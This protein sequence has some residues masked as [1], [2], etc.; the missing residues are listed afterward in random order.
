MNR[1]PQ[2][3]DQ[4]W[5]CARGTRYPIGATWTGQGT[6]FSV[7]S[8][9]AVGMELLIW[10]PADAAEPAQVIRLDPRFN[11]TFFFWHVFVVGLPAGVSYNW[12]VRLPEGSEYG[13]ELEVLDPLARGILDTGWSRTQRTVSPGGTPLGL[14]GLLADTEYD[15]T[16]DRPVT[17]DLR[18]AVIYEMHVGHF[19]RHPS[20]GAPRPGSFA[21]AIEKIP[22]LQ[23]LGITHVQLMPVAAFDEQDVPPGVAALGL[24]N[25]WGYSPYAFSAP[26]PGYCDPEAPVDPQ[27]QFR[28]LVKALHAAGIGVILDVV[29]NHTAEGGDGGPVI[30]YKGL[31][32]DM[33]YHRDAPPAPGQPRPW[34]DYTGCGNTVNCNHPLVALLLVRCLET[35]VEEFRV[36]GFRFD[37][38]SVFAR[39]EDG[40]PMHNPPLPWNIEFSRTL[41]E[42][43]MIA[44]AWDA[45]GLYQLGSFPGLAWTEWNGRYRDV[46]RRFVRGE[47]GLAGE[48]ASCLAGSSDLYQASGRRPANS[49]NFITCHDG[50]TLND[51]VSYNEKHNEAN[52]EGNRDGGNHDHSWNCGVEGPTDDPEITALR[53]RQ[54]RN[55]MAI[56]LLSQGVPM[57]LAGDEVLRSQRGNNNAWCQDD[58]SVWFDW[59]RLESHAWMLDFT[60][61]MIA[62]RRRH[63]TLMRTHFLSGEPE[64]DTGLPD[65]RWHGRELDQP[66]WEDPEARLLAF[67]LSRWEPDEEDL[68]VILNMQDEPAECQLPDIPGRRWY[69]AGDTG[70]VEGHFVLER[71]QQPLVAGSYTCLA[72]SVVVLEAR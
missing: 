50:F 27:D 68:H 12:R 13:T 49:I 21:A 61:G 32:G 56:L 39:G 18:T 45:A 55:F 34:R 23:S 59:T 2:C 5:P 3:P 53:E 37:L 69:R 33:F 10:Y 30:N 20:S 1:S 11:H 67:T 65:I 70:C 41:A 24:R 6:N 40:E 63:P 17:H 47:D 38:A 26:H 62:L 54:A 7:F 19:T 57:L 64:A 52:G 44:E 25:V 43:P 58:E 71:E 46:V 51:L 22:Y 15:W 35:W 8:R 28:D 16:G 60:R 9:E 4:R 14:R 42:L 72:R 48:V 36:D 66:P 29:F 31:A